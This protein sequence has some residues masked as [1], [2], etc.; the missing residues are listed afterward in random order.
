[1]VRPHLLGWRSY[2]EFLNHALT[3]LSACSCG[4]LKVSLERRGRPKIRVLLLDGVDKKIK[5]RDTEHL[6][7]DFIFERRAVF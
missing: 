7:L 1:M 2:I 4:E 6:V 5:N 3:T